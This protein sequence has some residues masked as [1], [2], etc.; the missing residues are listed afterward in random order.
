VLWSLRFPVFAVTCVSDD[1]STAKSCNIKN[2]A[3]TLHGWIKFSEIVFC[4]QCLLVAS[5]PVYV[6]YRIISLRQRPRPKFIHLDTHKCHISN[7]GLR[8]IEATYGCL[9]KLSLP[10]QNRTE[11]NCRVTGESRSFY[12][13]LY[14]NRFIGLG[15]HVF[16]TNLATVGMT[17]SE[18][19][20]IPV[21]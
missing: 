9:S 13:S 11:C 3:K 20:W 12:V 8:S 1:V 18:A 21:T 15:S 4:Q 6:N 17:V 5:C 7:A 14:V 19:I 10:D 16:D 2:L